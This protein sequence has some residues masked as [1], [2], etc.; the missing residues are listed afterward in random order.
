MGTSARAGTA[1]RAMMRDASRPRDRG[2]AGNVLNR[3]LAW[4]LSDIGITNRKDSNHEIF[5]NMREIVQR[6]VGGYS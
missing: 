1:V 5:R 2:Y 6:Y 3:V 4:N